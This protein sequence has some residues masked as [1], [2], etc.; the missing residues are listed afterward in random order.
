MQEV[1]RKGFDR[2]VFEDESMQGWQLI[3]SGH[4]RT[5]RD[6]VALLLSPHVKV[7]EF[8]R[9]ITAMIKVKGMRL[10]MINAYYPTNSYESDSAKVA[11]YNALSKA[12]KESEH[13]P[14]F[15]QIALVDLNAAIASSSKD[16]HSW[17]SILG[18]NNS[19]QVETNGNA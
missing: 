1:R 14:K 13:K 3:R 18:S 16:V 19:D 7:E 17:V 8:K 4:K 2:K 9:V 15:K 10:C 11:F 6:G 5:D 12:K